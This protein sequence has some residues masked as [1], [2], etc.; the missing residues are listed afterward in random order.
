MA[1]DPRRATR[2]SPVDITTAAFAED[3][4]PGYAE[5]RAKCPVSWHPTA[6]CWVVTRHADAAR[7]LRD[8]RLGHFGVLTS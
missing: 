3:P 8:S 4:L 7:L 1:L 5:L 2:L 6:R